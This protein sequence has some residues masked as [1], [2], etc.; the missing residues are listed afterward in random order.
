MMNRRTFSA[1]LLAGA[2]IGFFLPL[3]KQTVL[4]LDPL[5]RF[6]EPMLSLDLKPRSGRI[7]AFF[8]PR[9]LELVGGEMA[10]LDDD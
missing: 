8:R 4:N 5:N 6:K 2:A 1:T 10:G 9:D 7:V 3:P